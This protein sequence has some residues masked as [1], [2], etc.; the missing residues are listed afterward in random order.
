VAGTAGRE[1]LHGSAGQEAV[2]LD[3]GECA[4]SG[5]CCRRSTCSSRQAGQAHLDEGQGFC[6]EEEQ[7]SDDEWRPGVTSIVALAPRACA[8]LAACLRRRLAR[9][10]LPDLAQ[11]R[12]QLAAAEACRAGSR[13]EG[14]RAKVAALRLVVAEKELLCAALAAADARAACSMQQWDLA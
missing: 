13:K 12:A 4:A 6:G 8:A 2:S 9:Y 3:R 1:E 5:G 14:M 10:R 7:P 11:D